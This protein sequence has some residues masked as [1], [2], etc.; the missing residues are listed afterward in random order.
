MSDLSKKLSVV[1]IN[2][3]LDT[4]QAK[5]ETEVN[6]I[7]IL[8]YLPGIEQSFP[9]ESRSSAP[10]GCAFSSLPRGGA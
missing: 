9:K 8:P 1:K 10:Y 5:T 3:K 4:E 7:P 2:D 6:S